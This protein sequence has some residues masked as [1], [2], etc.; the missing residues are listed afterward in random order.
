MKL[1]YLISI[2][3]LFFLQSCQH[4][5]EASQPLRVK[6]SKLS[7]AAMYNTRLGLAYLN[8]GDRPR[9]KRKLLRALKQAP[10]FAP[11]NAAMAFFM[12]KSG[13]LTI[14]QIYYK[15]AMAAAPGRG[16][17]LN[18]YGA[19]L[20]RQGQYSQAEQYFLKAVND[21]QYEHTGGAY[22]NAGLCAESIP[23]IKKATKYFRQALKQDPSRKQSLYEVVKLETRQGH[24]QEALKYLQ[25]YPALTLHD[26]TLQALASDLAKKARRVE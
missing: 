18:N 3:V 2:V 25:E 9:A 8:Q 6:E 10:N 24:V 22:E 19:F 7:D 11:A 20:C 12:E 26:S 4:T 17:E 21:L 5:N 1:W 16:A 14:A 13:E 15:K 23:D